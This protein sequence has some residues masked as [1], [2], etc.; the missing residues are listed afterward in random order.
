MDIASISAAISSIQGSI[1]IV[2]AALRLKSDSDALCEVIKLQSQIVQIQNITIKMQAEY[3][4]L[5]NENERLKSWN[6]EKNKYALA[7]GHFHFYAKKP[8]Y[9]ENEAE[10][11]A[12]YCHN[13]FQEMR[14]SIITYGGY[15]PSGNEKMVCP[16]CK[17]EHLF[18]VQN[19]NYEQP[20]QDWQCL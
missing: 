12:K 7:C 13:C 8:E 18:P 15:A 20:V 19:F 14:L 4:N 10:K 17:S 16:A 2:S 1:D 3:M 9:C 6:E 5:F 11:T